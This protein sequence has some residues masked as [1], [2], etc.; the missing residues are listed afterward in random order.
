M[1]AFDISHQIQWVLFLQPNEE[2]DLAEDLGPILSEA[3]ASSKSLGLRFGQP[4]ATNS[5]VLGIDGPRAGPSRTWRSGSGV[6][7]ANLGNDRLDVYFDAR[8]YLDVTEESEF[9][10]ETAQARILPNLVRV[11]T[12]SKRTL[13]RLALV[14]TAQSSCLNAPPPTAIVTKTFLNSKLAAI[15]EDGGITD[16]FARVNLTGTWTLP[17]GPTDVNRFE[18]GNAIIVPGGDP[19]LLW[20]WDVNTSVLNSQRIGPSDVAAFFGQALSWVTS[21]AQRLQGADE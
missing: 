19:R 15:N 18:A 7:R 6:W 14:V 5:V 12:L 2:F 20:Q 3:V 16:A 9:S 8:G 1:L 4:D 21:Q 17:M 10:L 13:V 11:S